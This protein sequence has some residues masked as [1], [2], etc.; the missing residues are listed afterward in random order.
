MLK[1]D[2]LGNFAVAQKRLLVATYNAAWQTGVHNYAPAPRELDPA[3]EA[4]RDRD[5]ALLA[6]AALLAS[7]RMRSY[8]PPTSPDSYRRAVAVAPALRGVNAM[9][10]ELSTLTPTP[11]DVRAAAEAV[12][13]GTVS[14][15]DEAWQG[16]V[17][18]LSGWASDN[19]WRL[20]AGESV[21]WAGEQAGYAEAANSDGMLLEW[22]TEG[23][24]RVCLDC[25][26]LGTMGPMPLEEWPSVPGSGDTACNVGCRCSFDVAAVMP[27]S[28]S[29]MPVTPTPD[30]QAA[31]DSILGRRETALNG[32]MPDAAVLS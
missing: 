2:A 13:A 4:D 6:G 23:D 26:M 25:E 17:E 31:V 10:A 12:A 30:Q 29:Y 22:V 5:E 19:A 3:A 11:A 21:A 32:L 9:T 20:T 15:A 16:V 14:P 28:D 7:R 8:R 1:P 24:D 27:A 18:M